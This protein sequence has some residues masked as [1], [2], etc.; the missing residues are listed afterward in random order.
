MC[1]RGIVSKK[2]EKDKEGEVHKYH[3]GFDVVISTHVEVRWV[4]GKER[5]AFSEVLE[6]DLKPLTSFMTVP[7]SQSKVLSRPSNHQCAPNSHS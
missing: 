6:Y 2:R 4:I 3:L 5:H 7:F 1:P